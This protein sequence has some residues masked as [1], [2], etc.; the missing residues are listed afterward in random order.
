[1][2][3][4][5][6]LLRA[7]SEGYSCDKVATSPASQEPPALWV[8]GSSDMPWAEVGRRR[9]EAMPFWDGGGKYNSFSGSS[10]VL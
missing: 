4:K 8:G 3:V 9:E 7:S 6:Q 2:F 1:M 10:P 5:C